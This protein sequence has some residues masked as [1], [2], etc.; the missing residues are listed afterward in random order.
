MFRQKYDFIVVF[1]WRLRVFR[2]THIG[3][4]LTTGKL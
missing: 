3:V 1:V 4:K 2:W